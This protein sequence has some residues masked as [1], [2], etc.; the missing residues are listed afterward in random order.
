MTVL[1]RDFEAEPTLLEK[2]GQFQSDQIFQSYLRL[3]EMWHNWFLVYIKHHISDENIIMAEQNRSTNWK[4]VQLKS[5]FM[6][7]TS[8]DRHRVKMSFSSPYTQSSKKFINSI[9]E[10]VSRSSIHGRSRTYS[11]P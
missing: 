6:S 5:W 1:R 4:E 10:I 11:F 3:F 8:A 7:Q 2:V 9:E